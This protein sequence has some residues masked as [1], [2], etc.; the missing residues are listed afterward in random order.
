MT[1]MHP[2]STAADPVAVVTNR[3]PARAQLA[4]TAHPAVPDPDE[5]GVSAEFGVGGFFPAQTP[6]ERAEVD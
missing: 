4:T 5:V 6:L 2:T 1:V 3:E